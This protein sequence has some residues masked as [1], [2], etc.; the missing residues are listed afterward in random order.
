MLTSLQGVTVLSGWWDKFH[1]GA[2]QVGPQG[3]TVYTLAFGSARI[4]CL[5]EL[6]RIGGGNFLEAVIP[7]MFCLNENLDISISW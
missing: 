3:L 6:A 1:D 7:I 5:Q 4:D 2:Q